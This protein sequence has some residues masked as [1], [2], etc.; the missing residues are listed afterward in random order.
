MKR[1]H[2]EME[3]LQE[4][5][6]ICLFF[7]LFDFCFAASMWYDDVVPIERQPK[8]EEDEL[9]LVMIVASMDWSCFVYNGIEAVAKDN[10]RRN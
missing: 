7:L 1:I 2:V 9:H 5:K 3:L 4:A 8:N 10:K 6:F